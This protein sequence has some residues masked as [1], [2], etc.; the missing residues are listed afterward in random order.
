MQRGQSAMEYL[1]TYG[2]AILVIVLVLAV[3][4]YLGVFTPPTPT[5][6]S[7]P[8]P[9]HCS[10]HYMNSS[11][12]DNLY[13]KIGTTGSAT[14]PVLANVTV[15]GKACIGTPINL[16]SGG[17]QVAVLTCDKLSKGASYRGRI[18]LTYITPGNQTT[19]V[20]GTF[21]GMIES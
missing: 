7:A 17:E 14:S 9:F 1:M 19:N 12:F 5:I 16:A 13:L 15:N 11:A 8:A 3:L 21:S 18:V 20:N 4:F 6:C 10:E 2:W